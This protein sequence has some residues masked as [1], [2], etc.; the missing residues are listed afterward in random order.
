M[1][2]TVFVVLAII[3]LCG[4]SHSRGVRNHELKFDCSDCKVSGEID[5]DFSKRELNQILK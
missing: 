5:R 4:C 2:P 1:K 3:L